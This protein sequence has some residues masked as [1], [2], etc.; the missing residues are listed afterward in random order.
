[1]NTAAS[2]T[3]VVPAYNAA[4]YID[5]TLASIVE[6]TW[7][8][9]QIIV[10]DDGSTDDTAE[11]VRRFTGRDARI[12]LITTANRG[13]AAARNTGID[14]AR[15]TYVAFVD[16]DDL[17]APTKIERQVEALEKAPD[18]Y[19]AVYTLH[20][21]IDS[22]DNFITTGKSEYAGGFIY[23]RHA[24]MKYVGNGSTLLVRRSVLPVVGGFDSSYAQA[25]IGGC[26]DLDFELRLAE[27][28]RIAVI[29]ERLMG[30]RRYAGNMSSNARRMGLGMIETVERS[31]K[32]MPMLGADATR[33]ARAHTYRYALHQLYA[34]G[35]TALALSLS[36]RLFRLDPRTFL[37][38][39]IA[40][41][42]QFAFWFV[43]KVYYFLKRRIVRNPAR[44]E[45][46][47][48]HELVATDVHPPRLNWLKARN[49]R[50]LAEEDARLEAQIMQPAAAG[51]RT[52][53]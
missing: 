49:L 24:S 16:A 47:A 32:R 18:D 7:R 46:K 12:T 4:L 44:Y 9:L 1:M 10:V 33:S 45:K 34:G 23:A 17:W 25:G 5:R 14:N 30:Y 38:T 2:V 29:P 15:G 27:R 31:L 20:F 40:L 13:V 52:S 19:A 28:Y 37:D 11:R 43:R 22:D 35:E 42:G 39:Y 36:R 26:E 21:I 48:F 41:A 50:T 51:A 3:V 8:N 6:Q 53:S